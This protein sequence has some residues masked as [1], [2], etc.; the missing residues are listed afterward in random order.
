MAVPFRAVVRSGVVVFAGLGV[1]AAFL[2]MGIAGVALRSQC[3][4]GSCLNETFDP[5][6]TGS[7][8]PEFESE[9]IMAMRQPE[10]AFDPAPVSAREVD[11][12][13]AGG[14]IAA[15]F[16]VLV[17]PQRVTA[18][19][20]EVEVAEATAEETTADTAPSTM[21]AKRV[22]RS[23]KVNAAGDPVWP[24]SSYAEVM[25]RVDV[26]AT[27]AAAAIEAEVSTT[28]KAGEA[29][30]STAVAAIEP[31]AATSSAAA[32]EPL[33]LDEPAETPATAVAEPSRQLV[34]VQG[35]ATNVRAG[36]SKDHERLFVLDKG[37]EV[38][39]L[40]ATAEWVRIVDGK[41][42]A[43]WIWG[44]YLAGLDMDALPAPPPEEIAVAATPEPE[45]AVEP[46]VETASLAPPEEEVAAPV[47]AKKKAA[48]K[49]AA[50]AGDVRTV[51]GQ[52]VN[53]RSG[54]SS[55]AGKLF[56]LVGGSEVTV[57]ETQKGWLKITDKEGRTGWAYKSYLN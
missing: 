17:D 47:P 5:V 16:E 28:T 6:V 10:V 56:A 22:V 21:I 53:V 19:A 13:K 25:D 50:A 39:A 20:P 40:A 2:V 12:A 45:P 11:L 14:M 15:T 32:V 48:K 37:A 54:P 9:T 52:G 30:A 36:P 31:A 27:P 43:G 34:T 7:T 57:S 55:S 35:K 4:E 24:V 41:G 29:E 51:L 26:A 8:E 38:E 18:A 44:E 46:E 49:A 3:P 1:G 33:V 23:V 42:R